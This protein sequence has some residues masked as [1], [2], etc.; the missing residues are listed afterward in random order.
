[1]NSFVYDFFSQ[2]R[3]CDI[4]PHL[5]VATIY[6]FSVLYSTMLICHNQFLYS[7]VGGLGFFSFGGSY[8]VFL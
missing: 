1:M 2:C 7:I 8:E 5:Y 3:I 4:Y 6:S